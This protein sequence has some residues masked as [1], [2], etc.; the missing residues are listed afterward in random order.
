MKLSAMKNRIKE[1]SPQ[2]AAEDDLEQPAQKT[3]RVLELL[4]RDQQLRDDLA[5]SCSRDETR[6]QMAEPSESEE[7]LRLE[8]VRKAVGKRVA[9]PCAS[10]RRRETADGAPTAA[11]PKSC[12]K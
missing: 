11:V 4:Q 10:V 7:K 1:R 12:L 3:K 6:L 2:L 5:V 8:Q 9:D